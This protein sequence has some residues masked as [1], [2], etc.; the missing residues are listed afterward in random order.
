[1]NKIKTNSRIL[2]ILLMIFGAAFMRIMPHYPNFTPIAGMAL[3]G[4]AYFPNKKTAFIIPV[5]AMFLSDLILGFHSTMW[6]VYLSFILIAA[7]GLSLRKGK[8]ISNIILASTASS[9]L[10]F[11]IT[12]FAV[13]LA[14]G[15]YP[16]SY[17]GL[18]E[19][20]IAAIPFFHYTMLGDLFYAG[21]LFGVFELIQAKFPVIAEAKLSHE[22]TI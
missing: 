16:M 21:V 8:K 3:F 9:V 19:C 1:M 6:A 12:N 5:T 11:V 14:W 15:I 13:W 22:E 10:F 18:I 2:T 17:T 7:I 20:Y 4:G